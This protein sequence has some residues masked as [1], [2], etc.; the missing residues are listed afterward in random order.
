[1][2]S[3]TIQTKKAGVGSTATITGGF[4]GQTASEILTL[5]R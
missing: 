1:V 2:A 5:V 3:F 4:G